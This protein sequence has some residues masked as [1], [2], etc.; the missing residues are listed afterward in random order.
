[1]VRGTAVQAHR[2]P[3]G[4]I[5]LRAE[6]C[7]VLRLRCRGHSVS[8]DAGFLIAGRVGKGDMMPKT[9]LMG[10]G[11][12]ILASVLLWPAFGQGAFHEA[13]I[14]NFTPDSSTSWVP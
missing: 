12:G 1:M 8:G 6:Q 9:L 10:A 13:A 7:R 4:G 5:S 11:T 14:P 3:T 2:A